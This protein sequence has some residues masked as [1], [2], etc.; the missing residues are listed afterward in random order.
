MRSLAGDAAGRLRTIIA[1]LQTSGQMPPGVF[2][3]EQL[4]E[5]RCHLSADAGACWS[6]QT[7]WL[8]VTA[9]T[10]KL[11]E[12]GADP[13]AD[14]FARAQRVTLTPLVAIES[15]GCCFC[16][17]I[18]DRK[19]C[20]SAPRGRP[21]MSYPASSSRSVVHNPAGSLAVRSRT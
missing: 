20:A 5:A 3:K 11:F 7:K 10:I 21:P 12:R 19:R 14:A 8:M 2:W 1:W 4:A 17:A 13:T 15:P 9:I 16:N 6:G 18:P